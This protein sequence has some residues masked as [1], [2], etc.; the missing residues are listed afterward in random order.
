[1][2]INFKLAFLKFFNLLSNSIQEKLLGVKGKVK[3][4]F[5]LHHI[6]GI[7][8]CIIKN[9][10]LDIELVNKRIRVSTSQMESFHFENDFYRRI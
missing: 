9:V 4:R 8:I 10:N 6:I 7:V 2:R 3:V 5:F 1:M